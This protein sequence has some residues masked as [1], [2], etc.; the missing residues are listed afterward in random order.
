MRATIAFFELKYNHFNRK[1][2]K[3]NY[4]IKSIIQIPQ[5]FFFNMKGYH[6]IAPKQMLQEELYDF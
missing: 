3:M 4:S 1:S 2:P 6:D 5:T